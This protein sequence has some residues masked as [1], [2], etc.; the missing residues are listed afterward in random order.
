LAHVIGQAGT[1][2]KIEPRPVEFYELE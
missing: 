2:P 1:G